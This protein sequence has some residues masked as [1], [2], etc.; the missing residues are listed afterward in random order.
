MKNTH[1]NIAHLNGNF[2]KH[3]YNMNYIPSFVSNLKHSQQGFNPSS[4]FHLNI[5]NK[6]ILNTNNKIAFKNNNNNK[7]Q[8]INFI[9]RNY[10]TKY[11]N[12][13]NNNN[14]TNS[15]LNNKNYEELLKEK[16]QQI[17]QMQK[18]LLVMKHTIAK[19]KQ[20]N[21]K[22]SLHSSVVHLKDNINNNTNSSIIQSKRQTYR[23]RGTSSNIIVHSVEELKHGSCNSLLSTPHKPQMKLKKTFS[24]SHYHMNTSHIKEQCIDLKTRAND[25]LSN[26]YKHI[27]YID[28]RKCNMKNQFN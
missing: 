26:Y 24:L 3:K 2:L 1:I 27:L 6:F 7:Q 10:E 16:N 23:R 9:Q 15:T 14:T 22:T 13:N 19:L 5:K 18:R 21:I 11:N 17:A 4:P 20:D 8:H 25:L 12:N 28:N